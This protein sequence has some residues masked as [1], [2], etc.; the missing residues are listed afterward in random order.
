MEVT[1]KKGFTLIELLIVIAIV[2]ILAG[3]MVPMFNTSRQEAGYASSRA[4][5]EVIK[6][7]S[8]M[9]RLDTGWWPYQNFAGNE[10]NDYVG[11]GLMTN[12]DGVGGAIPNW[13]GPYLDEWKPDAWGCYYW[14][15]VSAAPNNMYLMGYG[16]NRTSQA[17]GSDDIQILICPRKTTL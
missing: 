12:D 7:A 8:F 15:R 13:R 14:W 16:P 6:K 9:L 5:M 11:K 1:M 10:Y 3:A 17:G 2:A 4:D